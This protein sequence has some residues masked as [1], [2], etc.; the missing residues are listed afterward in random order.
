MTKDTLTLTR[1]EVFL[2]VMA[3][4]EM[5]ERFQAEEDLLAKA[6]EFVGL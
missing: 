3:L 1:R 4:E 2:V 6:R 5:E